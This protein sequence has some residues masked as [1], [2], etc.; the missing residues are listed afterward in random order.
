MVGINIKNTKQQKGMTR[1][2]IN[3]KWKHRGDFFLD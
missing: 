3:P 2:N 1:L